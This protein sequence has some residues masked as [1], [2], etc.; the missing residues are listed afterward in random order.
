MSCIDHVPVTPVVPDH[1]P[2]H[3]EHTPDQTATVKA[4]KGVGMDICIGL[5][6]FTTNSNIRT[7]PHRSNDSFIGRENPGHKS[8]NI[9]LNNCQT[10]EI[11]RPKHHEDNQL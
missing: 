5:S 3:P 6:L 11:M 9:A 1:R 7:M 8:S 10:S 2:D 4:D